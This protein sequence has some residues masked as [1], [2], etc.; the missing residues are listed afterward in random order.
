MTAEHLRSPARGKLRA[1]SPRANAAGFLVF[2]ALA[3]GLTFPYF[4]KTR[5]A[6]EL[7][8]VMQAMAKTDTG[9]WAID[10]PA[11]RGLRPGP[12][13]S[14]SHVDGRIYPNKPPGT[15]AV[16]QVAY[17]VARAVHGEDLT[18]RL[19]T[20]WAR[21]LSGWL[22]TLLLAW[23]LLQRLSAQFS[24]APAVAAVAV[25]ALATPAAAYAHLAYGHQ[26]AAALLCIGVILCIDAATLAN[27][28]LSSR[29]RLL[30]AFG[31]GALAGAAV[32]VEYGAVFAGIPLGLFLLWTGRRPGR[33]QVTLT[34][35]FGALLPIAW[36]GAYHRTVYGAVFSTGYHHV[37]NPDFAQKHGQGFLGL[38]LPTWDG[39]QTHLLDPGGG[40]LWWAPLVPL[41]IYGLVRAS[42]HEDN[43]VSSQ[44]RVGLAIVLAYLVIVCSLSFT[45][46]WRIGP[47]Y[48]VAVL[49]FLAWGWAE[50]LGQIRS[51]P[52]WQAAVLGLLIYG[53]VVN[54]LAANLWPHLDLTNV[55]HPVSEVL[56]P[57]WREGVEPYG[58]AR[59]WFNLDLGHFVIALCVV[60]GTWA[61]LGVVEWTPKTIGAVVLGVAL[62]AMAVMGVTRWTPHPKAR[63]NLAYILRTW[64][65]EVEPQLRR[66]SKGLP[67]LAPGV[68]DNGPRRKP[69]MVPPR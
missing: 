10:G 19:L 50:A 56:L 26:L 33:L 22:P 36:L 2:L 60:G 11:G 9:V 23:F 62:G 65:P 3:L 34:A 24:R 53:L 42:A 1:H 43:P 38:S 49:P 27:D 29:G 55:H 61:V 15:T 35:L 13:V 31:G 16:I 46:G 30:R 47:R 58:I 51:R 63:R 52:L 21:M 68:V 18:L 41:A 44:A 12:D 57:L 40:L 25:Y 4:E 37:T 67:A 14:R 8:R 69:Q 28:A 7:P 6:N 39:V 64:E 32:T 5:N 54:A 45:G 59:S 48:I 17:G 66:P 20:W